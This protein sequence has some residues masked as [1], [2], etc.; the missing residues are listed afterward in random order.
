MVISWRFPGSTCP[1]LTHTTKLP[2]E[3]V[4]MVIL[5]FEVIHDTGSY[6][7]H[8]MAFYS[9]C[10]AAVPPSFATPPPPTIAASLVT[11][12]VMIFTFLRL[13]SFLSLQL[14]HPHSLR[15]NHDMFFHLLSHMIPLILSYLSLLIF[16]LIFFRSNRSRWRT[17]S[18]A[19]FYWPSGDSGFFSPT[20]TSCPQ[21][22][23]SKASRKTPT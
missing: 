19:I 9:H 16:Y 18:I 14:V 12:S 17:R 1:T 8:S 5:F 3:C 10:F 20:T 4:G 6:I 15:S 7:S 21:P 11:E 23:V 13:S 2:Q 22:L